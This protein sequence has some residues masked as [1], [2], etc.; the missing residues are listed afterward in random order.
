MKASFYESKRQKLI[1]QVKIQRQKV[2][3]E[4][5]LGY[6]VAP[7]PVW[8]DPVSIHSSKRKSRYGGTTNSKDRAP[9]TILDKEKAHLEKIKKRQEKE[10]ETMVENQRLQEEMRQKNMLKEQKEREKEAR[11]Q[12]ELE[13]KH[14]I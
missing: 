5:Q 12:Q 14:Q 8:E 1:E 11:R 7:M 9:S 6:W 13:K 2:I 3:Q 10:V 4:E